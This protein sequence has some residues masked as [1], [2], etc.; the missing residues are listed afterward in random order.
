MTERVTVTLT[1][2]DFRRFDL[3]RFA[4]VGDD[5]TI[6]KKRHKYDCYTYTVKKVK[7]SK[8]QFIRFLQR[9]FIIIKYR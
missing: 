7:W 8:Y 5:Q 4:S 2:G 1:S 9:L 6:V 3:I